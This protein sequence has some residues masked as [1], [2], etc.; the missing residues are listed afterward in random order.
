[1]K[2]IS[3]IF[4]ISLSLLLAGCSDFL[5]VEP[6]NIITIDQFWN[7][8]SDVENMIAG[9]YTVMED[10]D[11]LS[12][13]LIWGE[14]R[15][16]N[17]YMYGTII[18]QDKSLEKLLQEGIT[19]DNGYTN[20]GA[21]YNVINR[22]N[23]II[24]FAPQVSENDPS[25]STS[26]VNAHI[27]EATTL[28]TLSYFYLIRTFEKVPYTTEAFLDDSQQLARPASSFDAVLD[29]LIND[30]ESIKDMAIEE[31]PKLDDLPGY[32]N[33]GRITKWSVYAL[34]CELHL[35]KGNYQ[36]SID[37]ANLIIERKA[38][39]A[40]E[41]DPS[42]DYSDFNGY[43]LIPSNYKG[44]NYYGQA[45]NAIF[46]TGNSSE[47]I[48]EL[49]YDKKSDNKKLS[50]TPVSNFYGNYDRAPFCNASDYIATDMEKARSNKQ[51][52]FFSFLDGRG[53]ENF[54]YT[55]NGNVVYIN[56]YATKE[57]ILITAPSATSTNFF[58]MSSFG[59]LY[60]TGDGS[61]YTSRNKSNFIIYRLTDIMLLKAEAYTQLMSNTN[62]LS[63]QDL[64]YR[65]S[66]FVLID[67]VNKRSMYVTNVKNPSYASY[68]L[69]KSKYETKLS[70]T[71]LVYEERHRE[72]MF[73]G[74][75]YYDLIRRSRRDG[76]TEYL[77]THVKQKSSNA[78]F[79]ESQFKKF[80]R[81]YWPYNLNE[82]KV[83]KYLIQNSAFGSGEND[84]YQ[85]TSK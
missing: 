16:E 7:E 17:V 46:V 54:C 79:I 78:S 3:N 81:I 15:S 73:E 84:S 77:R 8:E 14:F 56:K 13:A 44:Q 62:P 42:A 69:D 49:N 64:S 63:E 12:R 4:A 23:I 11:Y 74:K 21:F 31:Y 67:A 10:N 70:I 26:E 50:N 1:M 41:K 35:W 53:Y 43:P 65:D 37:Y 28:R 34:L 9:C 61:K 47:S 68:E 57:E 71:D 52:V 18:E 80:E 20:W 40:I 72:L 36:Q 82:L 76:N 22:C 32:Y 24:K 33:T 25:Y 83:N 19:A 2:K 48:F 38:K 45:F 59:Q 30:M 58:G 39:E 6:Q 27:A 60:E 66:A 29:S 85:K 5:E 51:K 55:A 75:R